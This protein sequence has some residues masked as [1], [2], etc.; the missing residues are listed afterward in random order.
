M[1]QEFESGQ[2]V[3]ISTDMV[4]EGGSPDDETNSAVGDLSC[5]P[6]RSRF[7]QGSVWVIGGHVVGHLLRLANSLILTRMLAPEYYGQM[8]LVH[9]V[10]L[11]ANL[12]S[13]FGLRGS[14]IQHQ[15][16][17]EHA[18]LNTIWT[19]QVIRGV[20][21]WLALCAVAWPVS[22][23][24]EEPALLHLIPVVGLSA[25]FLGFASTSRMT[26][27]RHV[28]PGVQVMVDLF[29]Q[30]L[31]LGLMVVWAWQSK[32][33]WPLVG[34]AV[35]GAAFKCLSSYALIPG[36][37]VRFAWDRTAAIEI[38]HFG[39]WIFIGTALHMILMMA[40]RAALGKIMV[41]DLELI[42]ALSIAFMLSQTV[43]QAMQRMA[44]EVLFPVYARLDAKHGAAAFRDRII[45]VRA[46]LLALAL[47]PLWVLAVFGEAII[48]LFYDQRYTEAGWMLQILVVGT[49]GAVINLTAERV[50][51]ARGDSK[52]PMIVQ[53]FRVI[54]LIV[55]LFI[56]ARLG[57]AMGMLLGMAVAR[58]VDYP[59]VAWMV[60]CHNAWLWRLDLLA[61]GLSAAVIGAGLWL[62][63]G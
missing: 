23:F 9:M 43:L 6:L 62:T 32:T 15:R 45:K 36:Y 12:F 30:L 22:W 24:Y 5:L 35:F 42:G 13:D 14:V 59:V 54:L 58:L 3:S 27:S 8:F 55:A 50:A 2:I 53:F 29:G 25:I 60:R 52:R 18:F 16:G 11:V 48:D 51:L 56:G 19:I 41:G 40:P 34:G 31:A 47:P 26:L 20:I 21:L 61:Y 4:A 38:Y 10:V 1:G 49:V 33:V 37:R 44:H 57:D 7:I 17:D 46:V 63:G 39:K 28:R